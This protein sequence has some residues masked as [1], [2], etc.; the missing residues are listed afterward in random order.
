M[1]FKILI[2]LF[3]TFRNKIDFYIVSSDTTQIT[4]GF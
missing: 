3:L 4:Y 1:A 2:F